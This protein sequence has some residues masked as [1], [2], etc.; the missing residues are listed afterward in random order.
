M[1]ELHCIFNPRADAGRTGRRWPDIARRLAA[2]GF[3][4]TAHE[5]A[6]PGDATRL[7]REALAAG[8]PTIVAVGGD[9]TIHEVANGFFE[10]GAPTHPQASLGIVPGGSGSDLIKTL[11]IPDDVDGAIARLAAGHTRTVDVGR[12]TFI[13]HA[14]AE[15]TRIYLNTASAGL[16]GVVLD[17]MKDLPAFLT[18]S[19]AYAA[20][21]LL[22]LGRFRPF[23]CEV[24]L[25]DQPHDAYRALMVVMANGRYFGGGMEILPEASME[26]GLLDVLVAKDRPLWELLWNFPRLYRGTHLNSPIMAS[27]RA[28]RVRLTSPEPLLLEVDGEQPGVT[29]ATFEVV[30]AAMR[31]IV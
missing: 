20:A 1:S 7:A 4:V 11:G 27:M 13:D 5:T 9:G 30:P 17:R 3:S 29:P 21:T 19:A 25:D 10:A 22:S 8:A 28:R 26:D 14:G 12:V 23:A 6:A 18:G 15:A 31:V 24:T 16:S 2:A